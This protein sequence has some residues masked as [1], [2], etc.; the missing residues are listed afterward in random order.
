M[1]TSIRPLKVVLLLLT[2]I[3]LLV[4][5]GCKP[6]TPPNQAPQSGALSTQQATPTNAVSVV[7]TPITKGG[8][9]D[10]SP[11][12]PSETP[13]PVPTPL[14]T[15]MVTP[16]P[17]ASPPFIPEVV[18]KVPRPFWIYYWQG[19]EVWRVDDQGKD[20]QLVIDTYK[21]LGQ[22]LTDIPEPYQGSDCCSIGP[23]VVV[24]TDGQKLALVVVDKIKGVRGDGF[25]F[26][27]YVL[28]VPTG[29]LKIVSKGQFPKWSPDGKHIAFALA[30][31]P[32][33]PGDGGLW[34]A[35]LATG[36]L[37]QLIKGDPDRPFFKVTYWAWSPDSQR[38][39]YRFS[40]GIIDETAIWIKTTSDSSKAYLLSGTS[41]GIFYG[42]F[43][44]MP[45]GEH[46]LCTTQDWTAP[47]NPLAL[48]AVAIETGERSLLDHDLAGGGSQWSP[49]GQWLII[50]AARLYERSD[51]PYDL[52]LLNANGKRLLRLTSAPPGGIGAF[53][54]PDG[55][56]LVFRR[57]GIG[58]AT[59]SLQTGSVNPLGVN[60]VDDASYNYAVGGVK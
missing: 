20:K 12:P 49:D 22:Y 57:D 11:M 60:L 33:I 29:D 7:P 50:N 2:G 9:I 46:L 25:T 19:N 42:F 15:P 21:Q 28:D 40:E 55:T 27:I 5:A 35:D 32:G 41:D 53:W 45:D 43:S 36:Q 23:R 37:S 4:V 48:W 44:W 6:E 58:L 56:R 1:R 17:V 47:E 54:S 39:A 24:S 26:S 10:P 52:W 8:D 30:P 3:A 51:H 34:I 31:D 38:I 14:P 16:I 18:G 13:P 59:L